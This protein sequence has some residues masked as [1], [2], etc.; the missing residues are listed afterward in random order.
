M[1]P[2]VLIGQGADHALVIFPGI[3]KFGKRL[4]ENLLH[5]LA[6]ASGQAFQPRFQVRRDLYDEL[7]GRRAFGCLFWGWL[8]LGLR[9]LS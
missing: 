3:G 4:N 7:I 8:F 9:F 1:D 5:A 6:H 2:V